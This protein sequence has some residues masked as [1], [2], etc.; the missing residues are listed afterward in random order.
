MSHAAKET[1]IKGVAQALPA[2]V[3]SVFKLTNG[4]CDQFEKLIRDF[5]WGDD[6]NHR[7]VHWASWENLIKQKRKG[8][9]RL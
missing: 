4:F 8:W 6:L 7:K 1:L 2:F 9:P 3:M 5:W